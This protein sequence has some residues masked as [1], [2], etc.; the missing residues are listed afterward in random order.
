MM[1]SC[2]VLLFSIRCWLLLMKMLIV[3]LFVG[4]VV[5]VICLLSWEMSWLCWLSRLLGVWLLL[6]VLEIWLLM[7]VICWVSWLMIVMLVLRLFI[8][9]VCRLLSC[10]LVLEKCIVSLLVWFRVIWWVDGLLG[11]FVMF[12]IVLRNWLVV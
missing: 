6:C 4:S 12:I 7:L 11:W 9:L 5:M 1:V 10:W 8:I 3:L 2:C